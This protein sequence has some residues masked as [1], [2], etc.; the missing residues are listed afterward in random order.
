MKNIQPRITLVGAGPGDA[1]LITLKGINALGEADVILYDALVNEELLKYAPYDSKKIFVGKR[2]GQHSF[3]QEQINTLLVDYAF[4]HGHVVRLKG[5]D[6]FV[7]GR[8]LEELEFAES[9]NIPVG[10]IPGISSSIGV[11]ASQGIP[12]THRGIS[13][14]FWVLTGRNSEGKVPED[15]KLAAQSEATAVILMGL[16]KLPEIVKIYQQHG[17]GNLPV[18]VIQDGTLPTEN[19]A[20]GSIDTIEEAVKQENIKAP[21]VIVIGE[22]VRKNPRAAF[23]LSLENQLLN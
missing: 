21:A 5:G 13:E 22:V 12:V 10:W 11:P 3:T 2:D 16:K 20:I 15:V 19:A 9:F 8:G 6:P 4:T 18:A 23:L 17:K 1:E 14:S 7:F